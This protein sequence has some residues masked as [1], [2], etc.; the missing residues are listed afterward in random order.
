M[1]IVFMI[2]GLLST[3]PTLYAAQ[4]KLPKSFIITLDCQG[5]A[6]GR[7]VVV[8]HVPPA[9]SGKSRTDVIAAVKEALWSGLS[10]HP[11]TEDLCIAIPMSVRLTAKDKN[12]KFVLPGV[13][14]I[15]EETTHKH[16]TVKLYLDEAS[17]SDSKAAESVSEMNEYLS[18]PRTGWFTDSISRKYSLFKQVRT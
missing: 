6:V 11:D 15:L 14:E 4:L 18:D 5:A 2:T 17:G 9:K 12:W 7:Q 10:R 1:L 3:D 13:M 16:V 8:M